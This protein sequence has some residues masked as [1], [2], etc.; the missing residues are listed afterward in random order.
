MMQCIL[1]S[2]CIH[3]Q[4]YTIIIIWAVEDMAREKYVIY[5]APYAR[6]YIFSEICLDSMGLPLT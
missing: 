1:S 6:I 3:I 5:V 4:R 2:F